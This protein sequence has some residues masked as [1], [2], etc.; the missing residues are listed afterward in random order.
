M[1]IKKANLRSD[2]SATT[3]SA[4]NSDCKSRITYSSYSKA[5]LTR[6]METITPKPTA[7]LSLNKADIKTKLFQNI[8]EIGK[9]T[10]IKTKN[11]IILDKRGI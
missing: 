8:D 1:P 11:A 9:P 4:G 2:I 3:I 10:A 6:D 7:K 5:K